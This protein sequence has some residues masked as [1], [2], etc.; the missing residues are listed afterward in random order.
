MRKYFCE[1]VVKQLWGKS[2]FLRAY[3]FESCRTNMKCLLF[4]YFSFI[5]ESRRIFSHWKRLSK[6]RG[7]YDTAFRLGQGTCQIL[8][9]NFKRTRRVSC[10]KSRS[11]SQDA[12]RLALY[13][14]SLILQLKLNKRL[15]GY[16]ILVTK[17]VKIPA[18]RPPFF[19]AQ[20]LILHIL[21]MFTSYVLNRKV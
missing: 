1:R 15:A 13:R 18:G 7:W 8:F 9:V 6:I 16:N 2:V 12:S 3:N 10:S 19:K 14:F 4:P 20:N 17:Y 21:A 11:P 5:L